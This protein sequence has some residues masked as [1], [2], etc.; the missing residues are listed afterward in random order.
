MDDYLA[1]PVD[2][3]RLAEVL[4]RWLPAPRAGATP[5]PSAELAAEPA[6]AVFNDQ[7]LLR[8]LMGDRQLAG[9]LL[10]GFLRDVPS[11][12]N[13]LHQRLAE[14]DGAGARSQ[15]HT[16]KGAAA[17]VAAES[18]QALALALERAG[19]AGQ[20]D[21]CRELLPRAAEEFER[22]RSTLEIAGWV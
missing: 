3:G 5:Q 18:L 21:R 15:A 8:R 17:T 13:H 1:K 10:K 14:A 9:I 20:L 2:L 6:Q 7:A 19:A 11:Q 4:A 16:L 12:L 22:F